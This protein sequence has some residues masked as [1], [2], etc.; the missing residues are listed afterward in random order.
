MYWQAKCDFEIIGHKKY[1][2]EIA[3]MDTES[4]VHNMQYIHLE[5]KNRHLWAEMSV[6]F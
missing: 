1:Y 2:E 3:F 5:R 4:F 6:L